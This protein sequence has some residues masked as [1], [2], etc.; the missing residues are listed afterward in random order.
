MKKSRQA[1]AVTRRRLAVGENPTRQA[2][3]P[4]ATAATVEGTRRLQPSG[5]ACHELW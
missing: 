1:C 3:Q 4:A 2:L 5:N